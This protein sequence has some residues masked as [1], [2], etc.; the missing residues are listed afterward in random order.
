MARDLTAHERELMAF[1]IHGLDST[2]A[3]V[4]TAQLMEL[5]VTGGSTTMLELTVS[6]TVP[7]AATIDGPLP[8]RA[9]VTDDTGT[10]TGELLLW[11]TDGYLSQLEYAWFTE[12]APV[13]LPDISHISIQDR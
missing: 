7:K 6:N 13:A 4:F 9:V 1:I 2:S 10:A 11:T 3:T 12:N 5:R 8:V